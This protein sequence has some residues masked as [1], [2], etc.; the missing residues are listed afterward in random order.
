MKKRNDYISD[1]LIHSGDRLKTYQDGAPPEEQPQPDAPPPAPAPVE[2]PRPKS[3]VDRKHFEDFNRNRRELL[4]RLSEYSALLE[5]ELIDSRKIAGEAEKL[6]LVFDQF[7]QE[8]S[9][10]PESFKDI[11]Q[12]PD[13][14]ADYQRQLEKARLV[15]VRHTAAVRKLLS[16]DSEHKRGGSNQS[17]I[18]ELASLSFFQLFRLGFSFMMPIMLAIIVAA[19]L[20]GTAILI[21]MGGM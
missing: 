1:K 12:E 17:F 4:I 16:Y 18:H 14:F 13:Q 10:F 6:Q 2:I 11:S 8:I 3:T 9:Q 5:A 19:I 20:V 15:I 21:T 7:F